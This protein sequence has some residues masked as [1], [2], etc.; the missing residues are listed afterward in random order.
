[1]ISRGRVGGIERLDLMLMEPADLDA[2]LATHEAGLHRE[3][4]GGHLGEGRFAG[5]VDAQKTDAVVDVEPQVQV[6]QHGTTVIA[7]IRVLELHEWRG[8]GPFGRG[9]RERRHAL[10][11]DG[12]DRLKLCQPLHAGLRLGCLA[13]LGTE[14]IDEALKMGA[15][16]FLL[17]AGGGLQ[18]KLLAAAAFEIVVAAGIKVQLTLAH[19][20]DCVDRIVEQ[21]PVMADDEGRVRVL[22][23]ACLEPEG[24]FEIEVVG[25]LVEQQQVGLGKKRSRQRNAHSPAAGKLRHRTSQISG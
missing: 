16:C 7:Y 25:R 11:D 2:P 13:G 18:A 12:R 19:V 21:F 17:V 9:E 23:E 6:A 5:A 24:A 10:L 14:P 20:E 4:A 8:Q 15:L 22:P 3:R 1:M